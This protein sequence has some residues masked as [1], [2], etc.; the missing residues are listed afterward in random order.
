MDFK[1]CVRFSLQILSTIFR[2]L[3]RIR[4]DIVTN[5]LKSSCKVRSYR[6]LNFID[7]FSKNIQIYN[8]IKFVQLLHL[9]RRTDRQTKIKLRS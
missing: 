8:F 1:M 9:G 2:S 3:R 6:K 7:G 5:T 4:G